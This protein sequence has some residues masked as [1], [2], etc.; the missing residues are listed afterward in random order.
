MN[1]HDT[2][3]LTLIELLVVVAIIGTIAAIAVPGLLRARISGNEASGIGSLRAINTANVNYMT[4][5]AN[6]AGYAS[7]L[8]VLGSA[9]T[10]G[11]QPFISPDLGVGGMVNKAG[12]NFTYTATGTEATGLVTCM[13]ATTSA[14]PSYFV[15][16][17][18]ASP[19]ISGMRY[20]GTSE[21]QTIF[22][23]TAPITGIS[24]GGVPTPAAAV[25]VR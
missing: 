9:P 16:A 1:T 2:R 25:P 14:A 6:G 17:V 18:P 3:G 7:T 4:N 8:A 15:A 20:F 19:G 23:H 22:Q 12:Y 13:T 11:G 24:I 5:C 21:T 10:S